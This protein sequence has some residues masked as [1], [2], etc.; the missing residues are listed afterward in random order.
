VSSPIHGDEA[1]DAARWWRAYQLA[2]K[3]R[4]DELRGLAAAGDDHARSQLASWLS[5][6]AYPGSMADPAKL[7]E[8]IEVIRPLADAGDDVAELWLATNTPCVSWP[9]GSSSV[10]WPPSCVNFSNQRMPTSAS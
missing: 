6:R 8:A 10:T 2:E 1:D 3:D 5:D 4:A 9:G 7:G